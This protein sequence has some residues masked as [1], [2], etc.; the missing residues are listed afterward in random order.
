M[1]LILLVVLGYL[2]ARF[3]VDWL[4]RHALVVSGAEYLVLGLLLGPRGTELLTPLQLEGLAPF[5]TLA[6]GWMGVSL[7][8]QFWLP[9][10]TRTPGIL[11][12]LAFVEALLTMGL[13]GGAAWLLLAGV[14]IGT[15]PLDPVTAALPATILGAIA[16]TSSLAGAR[17]AAKS[18]GRRNLAVRQLE[19]A[20]S[21]DALVAVVAVAVA[22]AAFH[23]PVNV[24]VREPTS[25]EWMVIAMAVGLVGGWLFHL[26]LGNE[27]SPDRLFIAV[28]GAVVLTTGAA[29]YIG[30]SALLPGFLLGFILVNTSRQREVVGNLLVRVDRP[31]YFLMLVSAGAL[32]SPSATDVFLPLLAFLAL[33]LVG[34]VGGAWLAARVNGVIDAFGPRWGLALVGQGGLAIAIALDYSLA[35]SEV[36]SDLVFTAALASVLLTDLFSARLARDVVASLPEDVQLPEDARPAEVPA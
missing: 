11:F 25:T 33:R 5:F 4:A 8:F 10:L 31:L 19:V 9:V 27:R 20:A 2:A 23:L 30:M 6:I 21:I 36:M 13:V 28:A 29:N 3:A 15:G 24:L 1:L 12:R 34:K 14:P 32:W 7:G 18:L 17:I 26:F 35:R 22:L 16:T